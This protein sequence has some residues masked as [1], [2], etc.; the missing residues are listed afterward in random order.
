MR[1]QRAMPTVK[2]PRDLLDTQ[3]VD[4]EARNDTLNS[5][6]AQVK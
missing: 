3:L 5:E 4:M 2:T 6:L 1:K